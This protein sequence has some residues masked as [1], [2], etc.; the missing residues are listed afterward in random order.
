MTFDENYG[1]LPTSTLR[2]IRKYNVTPAEYDI[3]TQVG[4]MT[5]IEV[6]DYILSHIVDGIFRLPLGL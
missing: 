2:L 6:E 4:T 3:M 5:F 1:E